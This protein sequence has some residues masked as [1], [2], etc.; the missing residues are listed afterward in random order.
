MNRKLFLLLMVCLCSG[1]SAIAQKFDTTGCSKYVYSQ[2]DR[3]TEEREL[4]SYDPV[5]VTN[6]EGSPTAP[7]AAAT[8]RLEF[9]NSLMGRMLDKFAGSITMSNMANND[10]VL[11]AQAAT[12]VTVYLIFEGEKKFKFNVSM[13]LTEK[14][15]KID[16]PLQGE[17]LLYYKT[18]KL[19]AMRISGGSIG[20][21]DFDVDS[22]QANHLLNELNCMFGYR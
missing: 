10:G 21:V 9:R 11:K 7:L 5:T 13:S 4:W 15:C 3:F 14:G 22:K 8:Y 12:G 6:I 17:M 19:V 18:K 16:L 2:Y 20:N 1:I